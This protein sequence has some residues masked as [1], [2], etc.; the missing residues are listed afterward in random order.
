MITT[1]D[2]IIVQKNQTLISGRFIK[3]KKVATPHS[4]GVAQNKI[5]TNA[6]RCE[7]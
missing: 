4:E 1:I 5:K 6:W 2:N 7:K 3:E